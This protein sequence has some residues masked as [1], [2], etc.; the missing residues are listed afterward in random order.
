MYCSEIKI[1]ATFSLITGSDFFG[2]LIEIR[3]LTIFV[4][5]E[6]MAVKFF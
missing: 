2:Y 1:T 6:P 3:N 5:N 4:F